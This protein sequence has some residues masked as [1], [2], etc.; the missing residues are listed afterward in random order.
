MGAKLRAA[1]R[2][3]GSARPTAAAGVAQNDRPDDIENNPVAIF[4]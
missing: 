1:W 2:D 4:L 3:S